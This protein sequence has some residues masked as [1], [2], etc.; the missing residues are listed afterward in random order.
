MKT[1]IRKLTLNKANCGRVMLQC[2]TKVSKDAV[3]HTDIDGIPHIIVSSTTLPDDIVMNGIHYPASEIESSYLTLERTLAPL[4]HPVDAEGHF[5]SA[6]DPVAIANFY[7][8]AHN[9]NVRRENGRVYIDKVINVHEAEKSERGRRLLE[10]IA[11]LETNDEARPVHTSVGVFLTIE[12]TDGPQKNS[13]EQEYNLIAREMVFDHDAILLDSVGAATPEQGVGLAVNTDGLEHDVLISTNDEV[14]DQP[15]T[16]PLSHE[17]LREKLYE[18][19]NTPP[20]AAD[21]IVQVFDEKCVYALGEA[22]FAVDYVV[23][24]DLVTITGIPLAVEQNVEY[25]PKTNREGE[26][27]KEAIMNALKDAGVEVEGL[28]E[29]QILEAYAAHIQN[30]AADNDGADDGEDIGAIVANALA[31]IT[32]KLNDLEGKIDQRDNDEVSELAELVGN[33]E[34]Y[35]G[36]DAETAKALPVEKLKELAANCKPSIGLPAQSFQSNSN[37]DAFAI[38]SEMP[39]SN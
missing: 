29:T 9:E 35:P 16:V 33:S 37:D 22:M 28:N 18:K 34:V 24:G 39:S 26:D 7:A 15:K 4:E 21:Y 2:R 27:M 38:P 19:L 36:I 3:K 23:Q 25:T 1:E 14:L 32:E 12:E 5:L 17:Q 10:R 6:N 31:P 30:N 8:G 20:L 11:E 13:M